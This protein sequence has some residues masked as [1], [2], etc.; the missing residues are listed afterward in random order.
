MTRSQIF[1]AALQQI[2]EGLRDFTKE[3]GIEAQLQDLEVVMADDADDD[4]SEDSK[5][6]GS[7]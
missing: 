7:D 1:E 5:P 4:A 3:T 6:G 2:N